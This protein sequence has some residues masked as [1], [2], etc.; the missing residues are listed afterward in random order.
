MG[1]QRYWLWGSV[2]GAIFPIWWFFLSYTCAIFIGWICTPLLEYGPFYPTAKMWDTI[3][4]LH[5]LPT[6]YM[7][8]F[9]ALI[10]FVTGGI[11]GFIF[12]LIKKELTR[13]QALR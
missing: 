3:P 6:L 9:S 8:L 11:I 7:P 13:R 1:K 2:I 5:N 4:L 10:W 12:G